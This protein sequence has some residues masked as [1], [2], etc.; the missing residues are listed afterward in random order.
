MRVSELPT[1]EDVHQQDMR[2]WRYRFWYYVSRLRW[3]FMLKRTH[4]RV[5]QEAMDSHDRWIDDLTKQ[6]QAKVD[7]EYKRAMDAGKAQ[8]HRW[9]V[10]VNYN[11]FH[12]THPFDN[13]TGDQRVRTRPAL[14]QAEHEFNQPRKAITEE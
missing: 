9:A 14:Q 1:A 10:E 6:Y 4:D 7:A 2:D 3:P 12:G 13:M 11:L 5:L 8:I